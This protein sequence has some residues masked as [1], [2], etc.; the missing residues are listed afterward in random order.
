MSQR[1]PT[2]VST[3][4]ALSSTAFVPVANAESAI[5]GEPCSAGPS[6]ADG[7][8]RARAIVC[9]SAIITP[10]GP[11]MVRAR[12]CGCVSSNGAQHLRPFRTLKTERSTFT[13]EQK[14]LTKS[15]FSPLPLGSPCHQRAG[16]D[17]IR[18]RSLA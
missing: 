8:V 5:C 6:F 1:Q 7:T 12:S 13:R 4:Y 18:G 9:S 17:L 11:V 3:L 16:N 15:F 2:I 14:K 10:T